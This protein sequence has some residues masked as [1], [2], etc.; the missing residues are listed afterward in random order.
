MVFE[1]AQQAEQ[2]R[3]DELVVS[4]LRGEGAQRAPGQRRE[5][6]PIQLLAGDRLERGVHLF[7][8]D[9]IGDRDRAVGD[10]TGEALCVGGLAQPCGQPLGDPPPSPERRWSRA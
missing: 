8:L 9:E 6:H 3:V 10:V 4:M 7:V 1:G 5:L 2:R